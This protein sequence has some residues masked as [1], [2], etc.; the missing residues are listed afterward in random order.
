[1]KIWRFDLKYFILLMIFVFIGCGE[2]DKDELKRLNNIEVKVKPEK[3]V[4]QKHIEEVIIKPFEEL[5]IKNQHQ[6]DMKK[7]EFD[8]K[9][10]E[11][12]TKE[13]IQKNS[14]DRDLQLS[15]IEKERELATQ[16][17]KYALYR[18]LI[19][20]FTILV[21]SISMLI[22]FYKRRKLELEKYDKLLE[23]AMDKDVDIV[24]REQI[25]DVFKGNPHD[26][27]LLP[28]V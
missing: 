20:V 11:L 6:K 17:S 5:K 10:D 9:K 23:I 12:K 15:K 1:M 3:K 16:D 8:Y 19:V 21:L 26:K 22:Y 7:M 27:K 25:L 4:K 13:S 24:T 2:V 14:I 28:F 18:V